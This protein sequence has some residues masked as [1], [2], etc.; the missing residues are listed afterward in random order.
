MAVQALRGLETFSQLVRWDWNNHTHVIRSV[1]WRITDKPRFLHRAFMIDTA[2]HYQPLAVFDRLLDGMAACKLNTLHWHV[3]DAQSV[4]F[5]SA[6][7]PKIWA[8]RW[9]QDERYSRADMAYVVEQ[10]PRDYCS[11]FVI[12][13]KRL[14]MYG[15]FEDNP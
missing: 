8:G 14:A 11:C 10:V 7:Y 3:S 15:P 13:E 4:A 1:P 5:E 6:T 9:S 12:P 2:R